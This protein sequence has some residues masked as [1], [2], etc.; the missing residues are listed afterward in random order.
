MKMQEMFSQAAK[1]MDS[2]WE[3]WRQLVEN[4]PWVNKSQEALQQGW[5]NW[6]A[7]MRTA[8]DSNM[9]VWDSVASQSEKAFFRMLKESPWYSGELENEIREV[10]EA[11]KNARNTQ[12]ELVKENFD[13]IEKLVKERPTSA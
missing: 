12:M 6:I 1:M 5:S 9:A 11:I 10:A 7:N 8:Y 13:R 2:V 3:P 4:P